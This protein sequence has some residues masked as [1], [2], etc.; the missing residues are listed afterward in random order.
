MATRK[1]TDRWVLD[2]SGMVD[3]HDAPLRKQRLDEM[4]RSEDARAHGG[5]GAVTDDGGEQDRER[6]G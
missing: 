6:I 5:A 1:D 4:K 3:I 2:A